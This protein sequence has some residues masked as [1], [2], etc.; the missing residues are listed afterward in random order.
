MSRNEY[1]GASIESSG[2]SPGGG[3][4]PWDH[5]SD[6]RFLEYYARESQ[7]AK[8]RQRLTSIRD[9][10]LRVLAGRNRPLE[11]LDVADIGCGAGTQCF[12]WSVLGHRAHG[13]DVNA[14][15][16]ELAR[17]RASEAGMTVDFQVGSA[18]R[19]PWSD[20]SMD[21]C[22]LLEL[23]EHVDDWRSCVAEGVRILRP[24]GILFITTTN[25]LC[26]VQEEF[27]LPCYSWYPRP[28]KRWLEE[29]ART[30]RPH[31]ANYARY[32]AVNWFSFFSLREG[33]ETYGLHCYDRFD[34]MEVST[35]PQWVQWCRAR[36]RRS[37]V[38]RWLGH[39]LTPGTL[40]LAVK[41][42]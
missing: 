16:I 27:N 34:A 7:S 36:I 12:V 38:L 10:I 20:S 42:K 1:N 21:V 35:K 39:V 19:L 29:L 40:L 24:G 11:S 17:K 15:L 4:V 32:P 23:L 2:G 41:D 9:T 5:S 8:T 25:C 37:Q 31:L 30:S 28:L 22:L 3:Q 14:P 26:P 6:S 18:V 33:L 13:L